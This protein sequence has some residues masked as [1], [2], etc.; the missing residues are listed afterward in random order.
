MVLQTET[1]P[2]EFI[3]IVQLAS[4]CGVDTRIVNAAL[5]IG[6]VAPDAIAANRKL[7]SAS[8][9]PEIESNLKL[10]LKGNNESA[11]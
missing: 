10:M 8:R 11:L 1:K 4:A 3:G 2:A 9:I 7:F 5:Q 6:L